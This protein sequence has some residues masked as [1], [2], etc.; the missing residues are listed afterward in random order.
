MKVQDTNLLAQ[1]AFALAAAQVG[2][3]SEARAKG[4]L[5]IDLLKQT[6]EP[7]QAVKV[8]VVGNA[9]YGGGSSEDVKSGLKEGTTTRHTRL[10]E[11][12]QG[13]S[14]KP[15]QVKRKPE[16]LRILEAA[17]AEVARPDGQRRANEL[18]VMLSVKTG[19]K[20]STIVKVLGLDKAPDNAVDVG[21]LT[22]A[23]VD[24]LKNQ[25]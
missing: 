6:Y 7:S 22:T 12:L 4:V 16:R 8:G 11:E 17:M 21:A 23:Y 18:A 5:P 15:G 20:P 3:D 24:A 19:I 2:G 25:K 10:H 13:S 9:S 14:T 1:A